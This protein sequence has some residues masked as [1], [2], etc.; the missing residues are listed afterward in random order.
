MAVTRAKA[1]LIVV[2]NP[3]T[4]SL[5]PM[6]RAWL[7][8]VHQRGG[9]T[10]KEISWNPNEDVNA[11]GGYDEQTRS[12]AAVEADEM[13]QRI[14]AQIMNTDAW[15]IWEAEINAEGDNTAVE[16]RGREVD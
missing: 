13:I 2:G 10:G 14:R 7:N 6:W 5:D 8:F 11:E 15:A 12:K 9:W 16:Y 3:Q 1:L 4:L